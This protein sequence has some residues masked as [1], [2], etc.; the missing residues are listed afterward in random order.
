MNKPAPQATPPQS[1]AAH[2]A[3]PSTDTSCDATPTWGL[4]TLDSQD[5]LGDHHMVFIRHVGEL[6]RLQT[7]RQGKLILTK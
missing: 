3:T 7:T 2:A 4:R 1:E 5:L 6:Y